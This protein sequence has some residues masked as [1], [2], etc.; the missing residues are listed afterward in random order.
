[1]LYIVELNLLCKAT[2][3]RSLLL[4]ESHHAKHLVA[5]SSSRKY[6]NKSLS[7]QLTNNLGTLTAR[8]DRKLYERV[9][10]FLN[11]SQTNLRLTIYCE[12]FLG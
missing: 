4:T 10:F 6:R 9:V 11:E 5:L 3:I 1:M 7:S 2:R 12:I 8:V